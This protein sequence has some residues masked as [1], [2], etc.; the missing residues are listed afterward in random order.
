LSARKEFGSAWQGNRRERTKKA[1][2][3]VDAGVAAVMNAGGL[4][5][6]H[7]PHELDDE[8]RAH[9]GLIDRLR[10]TDHEFGRLAARY[11]DV[12][13]SIHRIESEQEPAD[14]AVA[15]E[16]KKERL[17]LKD[18]IAAFLTRIERRM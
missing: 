10:Q 14:D 16:F 1:G 3:N 9:A 12:N 7:I 2:R 6:M 4:C 8:F 5:F 17:L 15:E 13:R 18:Q 11:D